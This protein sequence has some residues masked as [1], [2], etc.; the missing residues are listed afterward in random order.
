MPAPCPRLSSQ[1]KY[2]AGPSR[3]QPGRV[4]PRSIPRCRPRPASRRRRSACAV[5]HG[6]PSEAWRSLQVSSCPRGHPRKIAFHRGRALASKFPSRSLRT[7]SSTGGPEREIPRSEWLRRPVCRGGSRRRNTS[8]R[9]LPRLAMRQPGRRRSPPASCPA[10]V[11]NGTPPGR[12]VRTEVAAGRSHDC[13]RSLRSCFRRPS[14]RQN[15][16]ESGSPPG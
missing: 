6:Y 4:E 16:Q 13:R 7:L 12:D 9:L 2:I 5:W 14:P 1:R 8:S 11:A 10:A 15:A 3:V